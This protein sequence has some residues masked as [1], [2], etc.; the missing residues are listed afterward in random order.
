MVG[1]YAGSTQPPSIS[2]SIPLCFTSHREQ[3]ASKWLKVPGQFPS[4]SPQG[5]GSSPKTMPHHSLA[6][7][8]AR[9]MA[10]TKSVGCRNN[11]RKK[12]NRQVKTKSRAT[13]ST[14]VASFGAKPDAMKMSPWS[15]EQKLLAELKA[16]VP[17]THRK[18]PGYKQQQVHREIKKRHYRDLCR[19]MHES[20]KKVVDE[21]FDA[22]SIPDQD[23]W[24]K[25]NVE[26]SLSCVSVGRTKCDPERDTRPIQWGEMIACERRPKRRRRPA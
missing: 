13:S 11:K 17:P 10:P 1:R 20:V 12:K 24:W 18:E 7:C 21:C 25:K 4:S 22:K 5:H 23:E 8:Q 2:V 3:D 19:L 9:A 6:P 26:P 15:F 14:R 16:K